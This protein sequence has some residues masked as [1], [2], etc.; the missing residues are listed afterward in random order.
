MT[1]IKSY[2]TKKGESTT[3]Y[4]SFNKH[5]LNDKEVKS[6][7][8]QITKN[9]AGMTLSQLLKLTEFQYLRSVFQNKD[10]IMEDNEMEDVAVIYTLRGGKVVNIVDYESC[11]DEIEANTTDTT[12]IVGC[13]PYSY[14]AQIYGEKG[15]GGFISNNDH[16]GIDGISI[17][18]QEVNKEMM[19]SERF[20]LEQSNHVKE[21]TIVKTKSVTEREFDIEDIDELED[22]E[23]IVELDD[24]DKMQDIDEVKES[25]D[26]REI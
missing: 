2:I 14:Y 24:I 10:A 23:D 19:I 3:S 6:R 16:I 4:E 25:E 1:N 11:G 21:P 15:V 7:L 5:L 8:N 17:T 12:I 20:S 26:E 9:Y 18:T 22:M 13:D